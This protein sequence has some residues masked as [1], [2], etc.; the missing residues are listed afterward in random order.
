MP[1]RDMLTADGEDAGEAVAADRS[2][3][4]SGSSRTRRLTRRCTDR[5][6]EGFSKTGRRRE[7]R[8]G[9]APY[10]SATRD[11]T[12]RDRA[13]LV[14]LSPTD[15][16]VACQRTNR[17]DHRARRHSALA[18]SAGSACRP[19]DQSTRSG[20]SSG[21]TSRK[22]SS[23]LSF[24][25]ARRRTNAGGPLRSGSRRTCCA[26]ALMVS[27]S[28]HATRLIEN[29]ID[30]RTLPILLRSRRISAR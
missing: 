30:L 3:T 7:A 6:G 5:N 12:P 14:R 15:C 10:I 26:T 9:A 1:T 11:P 27:L 2:S 25:R 13:T 18:R 8:T 17:P 4:R 19:R 16:K 24:L 23:R 21:R 22:G 20:R 28:N 29:G